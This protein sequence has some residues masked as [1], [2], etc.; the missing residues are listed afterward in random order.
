MRGVSLLLEFDRIR[1]TH[2]VTPCSPRGGRRKRSAHSAWPRS[3]SKQCC[4]KVASVKLLARWRLHRFC[5]SRVGAFWCRF[6]CLLGAFGGPGA[7]PGAALCSF[8]DPLGGFLES[9]GIPWRS[10]W[11]PLGGF[12][13]SV[14]I[15]WLLKGALGSFRRSKR[16]LGAS[17][18]APGAISNICLK[19]SEA[20]WYNF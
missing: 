4:L 15:L 18:G 1:N 5:F 2:L 9:L 14:G 3:F 8:G 19:F 6:R 12:L 7:A 16:A 20:F 17:L 13:D 10:F 11:G